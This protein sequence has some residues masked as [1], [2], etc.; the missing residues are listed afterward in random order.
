MCQAMAE[1]AHSRFAH[2][3]NRA[4][5]EDLMAQARTLGRRRHCAVCPTSQATSRHAHVS[6]EENTYGSAWGRMPQPAQ[7]T[8]EPD[9]ARAP[10]VLATHIP[11]GMFANRGHA[12]T[13][14]DKLSARLL[15]T[16][17]L[18]RPDLDLLMGSTRKRHRPAP[19]LPTH[20]IK[21]RGTSCMQA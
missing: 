7:P 1:T 3:H 4:M 6:A 12:A 2:R 9:D 18:L 10:S 17:R 8:R 16:Y 13:P 14:S 20:G 21:L 5:G 11:I 15:P 19:D